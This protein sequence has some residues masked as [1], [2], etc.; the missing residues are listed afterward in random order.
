MKLRI[1]NEDVEFRAKPDTPLLW[2]LR[3]HLNMT[4]TKF[5]CGKGLCGACTVHV[6]GQPVRFAGANAYWL[7]LD[8]NVM[9]N[10]SKVNYPTH[11]RVDDAFETAA[12]MGALVIRAHTI[13]VSTG[14]PLSFEPR[15]GVFA[16][17][18]GLAS[19]HI[20][21]AIYRAGISGIRLIVPLTDNYAYIHGG[22]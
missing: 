6:D 22:N 14:H 7:G 21:Y 20:D 19:D 17:G 8:E 13:G 3:D 1:N 16:E 5:G 12:G 10:G 11:F 9:I 4:G 15:F 2:V 18:D